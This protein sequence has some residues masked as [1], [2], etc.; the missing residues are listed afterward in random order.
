MMPKIK[1]GKIPTLIIFEITENELEQLGR[2]GRNSIILTFSIFF[3]SIV[4]ECIV[5]LTT[6]VFEGTAVRTYYIIVASVSLSLSLFLLSIWLI[7]QIKIYHLLKKIKERAL[8]QEELKES[9]N[10][11]TF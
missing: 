3:L 1:R 5:S 7:N 9:V 6:G 10:S 11:P 2:G 4:L 8:E